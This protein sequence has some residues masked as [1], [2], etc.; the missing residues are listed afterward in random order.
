MNYR[1]ALPARLSAQTLSFAEFANGA[2]QCHA[3]LCDGTTHSGLLVSNA[4]A[5]IAMRGETA[6][7]FEVA[8]IDRLFQTAED[9]NP[10][11]RNDWEFFDD[12]K[13]P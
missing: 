11:V 10:P 2:S 13:R 12:W 9:L 7:P 4:T 6:L 1:Y 5:I 3:K 8:M